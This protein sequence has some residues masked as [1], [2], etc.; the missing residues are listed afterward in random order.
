MKSDV[1]IK[2]LTW[3]I[4]NILNIKFNENNDKISKTFR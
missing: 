4:K 2:V 3:V 1:N